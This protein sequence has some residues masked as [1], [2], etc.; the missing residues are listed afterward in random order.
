MA[1]ILLIGLLALTG[2]QGVVGPVRRTFQTDTID[3]P[4]LTIPEQE[5][6]ARDRLGLPEGGRDVGPPTDASL[7]YGRGR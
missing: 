4:R 1:R 6:R 3:D 2:C 5:Q 7:P